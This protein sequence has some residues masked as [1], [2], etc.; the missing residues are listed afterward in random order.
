MESVKTSFHFLCH[1]TE[2][3]FQGV[4]R[5]A[6][7]MSLAA[8]TSKPVIPPLSSLGYGKSEKRRGIT[9]RGLKTTCHLVAFHILSPIY[10][11]WARMVQI[12][13]EQWDKHEE[14]G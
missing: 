11:E 7:D 12:T 3:V 9:V 10:S 14:N 1:K 6:S 5:D 4:N 13:G 2:G 8:A